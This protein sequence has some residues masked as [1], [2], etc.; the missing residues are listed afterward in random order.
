MNV[1]KT[2][3]SCLLL[4]NVVQASSVKKI[5]DPQLF[6]QIMQCV[7]LYGCNRAEFSQE[8]CLADRANAVFRSKYQQN[9]AQTACMYK[10]L[11]ERKRNQETGCVIVPVKAL[12]FLNYY[13]AA[14]LWRPFVI[15]SQEVDR[16]QKPW[17]S[18]PSAR[19]SEIFKDNF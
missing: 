8:A 19:L 9:E 13:P 6:K 17:R 10:I 3:L 11:A 12:L 14:N 4:A 2:V 15:A 5:V 1:I 7:R 18:V 16:F